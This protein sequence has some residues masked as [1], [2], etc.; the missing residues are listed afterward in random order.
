[1]TFRQQ[2]ADS[3]QFLALRHINAGEDEQLLRGEVEIKTRSGGFCQ[4][5][6]I[7]RCRD[8]GLVRALVF[9]E[10]RIAIN[11]EDCLLHRCH[12][13]GREVSEFAIDSV[14]QS[15][16][17]RSDMLVVDMFA[18]MKPFAFVVALKAAQK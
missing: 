7:K 18:R 15:F 2:V 8:V 9:G 16:Q 5:L 6:K 17:R 10:A 14:H 1:M 3:K 4:I 13:A 11:A 12:V